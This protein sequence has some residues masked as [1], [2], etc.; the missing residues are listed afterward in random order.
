MMKHNKIK[1][2]I[3]DMDGTL[4]NDKNQITE[5]TVKTVKEFQKQGGLFAVNTGRAID[6]TSVILKEAG[7][8]C[9]ILSLS[10]GAIH[11]S[12]GN[13][14][15]SDT[16]QDAEV[17]FIRDVEHKYGLL[18][19][20]MT[21]KGVI[22]EQTCEEARAHYLRQGHILAEETN[23]EISD[24]EIIKKHQWVL[25]I[26][27]FEAD[28]EERVSAGEL[29]YKMVLMGM[30]PEELERAKNEINGCPEVLALKTAP[31]T[32]EVN[33]ARVNKGLSTM[34]YIELKG[35]APEETMVIGDSGNDIPMF[36]IPVA[37]KIAMENAMDDLKTLSTHVTK[38]YND[39]GVAYAIQKWVFEE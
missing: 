38:S 8:S 25:D 18:A 6:T 26:V 39:D 29:V 1:V 10:G 32:I 2:V 21:T 5:D 7:I 16:M 30:D 23:R 9:D 20:Y 27:D 37:K 14:L 3:V 19:M 36:E 31:A 34:K 11:D 4:L 33:A 22:S 13:C 17:T 35:F 24:E 12:Q 28:I 15:M